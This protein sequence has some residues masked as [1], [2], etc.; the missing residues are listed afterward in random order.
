MMTWTQRYWMQTLT[1][2]SIFY[3]VKRD[4]TFEGIFRGPFHKIEPTGINISFVGFHS[5]S[6]GEFKRWDTKSHF[7]QDFCNKITDMYDVTAIPS[8]DG[9]SVVILGKGK[10]G[11]QNIGRGTSEA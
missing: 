4:L 10:Y 1:M 9:H 11:N 3:D 5:P 2:V 7:R 6:K 8:E